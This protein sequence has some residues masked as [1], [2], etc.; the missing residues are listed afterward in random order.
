M[1][2][3]IWV[4]K[5]FCKPVIGNKRKIWFEYITVDSLRSTLKTGRE[6]HISN[7]GS[8]DQ[9]ERCNRGQEI[10]KER[11]NIQVHN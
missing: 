4:H 2:T 8:G 6:L 7:N 11:K 10:F 3:F 1:I 9:I 5:L